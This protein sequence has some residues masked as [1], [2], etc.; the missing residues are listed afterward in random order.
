MQ[1]LQQHMQRTSPA[2]VDGDHDG[3][4]QSA[5]PA[6]ELAHTA[7]A[8]HAVLCRLAARAQE[9]AEARDAGGAGDDDLSFALDTAW[10]VS[11]V[12]CNAL[13]CRD[14]SFVCVGGPACAKS[15]L[16]AG[17]AGSAAGAGTARCSGQ[18]A[19]EAEAGGHVVPDRPAP[20]QRWV[21]HELPI[22]APDLSTTACSL[23]AFPAWMSHHS[24]SVKKGCP[25]CYL[26]SNFTGMLKYRACSLWEGP[27]LGPSSR[28][29]YNS[30]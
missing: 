14:A 6:D 13:T 21:K 15:R 2:G 16:C 25:I 30:Y 3:S 22:E 10:Q 1:L 8:Q 9:L 19:R 20:C 7:Q 29:P 27:V 24:Q 23:S 18:H 12:L 11:Q 26:H 17:A 28:I 4:A 5:Q